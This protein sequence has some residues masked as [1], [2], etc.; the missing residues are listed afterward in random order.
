MRF[1]RAVLK[2]M[3]NSVSCD[4]CVRALAVGQA[5][6]ES[7]KREKQKRGRPP[8]AS[9]EGGAAPGGG[10]QRDSGVQSG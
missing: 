8:R 1:G 9:S 10:D 4:V 2:V 6:K 5:A 3:T 7:A